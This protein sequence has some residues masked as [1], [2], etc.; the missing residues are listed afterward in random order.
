ML[1]SIEF[2][3]EI[4][5]IDAFMNTAISI[6]IFSGVFVMLAA[7]LIIRNSLMYLTKIRSILDDFKNNKF[8]TKIQPQ[9]MPAELGMMA[10]SLAD[11]REV[12]LK[13]AR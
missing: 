5:N 3:A 10:R 4:I 11:F 8:E 9:G 12:E 7:G 2:D 13:T 1:N 6:V